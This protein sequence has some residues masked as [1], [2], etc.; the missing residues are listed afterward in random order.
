MTEFFPFALA[1]TADLLSAS[2]P[3]DV[4]KG[5]A[6]VTSLPAGDSASDR[7]AATCSGD[8]SLSDSEATV[9]S[10]DSDATMLPEENEVEEWIVLSDEES[11][12]S[13]GSVQIVEHDQL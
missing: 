12:S 9:C 1:V 11:A 8:A 2:P 4:T 5:A 7:Q 10:Y 6:H 13:V 3:D